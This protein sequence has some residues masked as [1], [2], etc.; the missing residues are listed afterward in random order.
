LLAGLLGEK[1]FGIARVFVNAENLTN[2]RQTRD[3]SLVLPARGQGGR[4]T[5]D[6][7]APLEGFVVNGGVR[8]GF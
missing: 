8:L 4:W 3:D 5:T 7:W 1:R 6:V 2:V